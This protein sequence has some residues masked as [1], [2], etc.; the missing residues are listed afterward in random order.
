[1]DGKVAACYGLLY[2]PT[3][4]MFAAELHLVHFNTKYGDLNSAVD[5]EDGLAVLGVLIKVCSDSSAT[6]PSRWV[7]STRSLVSSAKFSKTSQTRETL[8]L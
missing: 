3:P 1:M 8:Y 7:P 4:Q 5:K 2:L 6:I